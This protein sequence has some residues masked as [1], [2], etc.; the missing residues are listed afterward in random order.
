MTLVLD[1][2]KQWAPLIWLAPNESFFPSN[3]ELFLNRTVPVLDV[4]VKINLDTNL[5]LPIGTGSEKYYLVPRSIYGK[6][7]F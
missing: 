7:E 1:I 3:V 6:I 4:N 5:T 2:I